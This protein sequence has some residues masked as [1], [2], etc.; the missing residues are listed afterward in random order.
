MCVCLAGR[1]SLPLFNGM[2]SGIE[3]VPIDHRTSWAPCDEDQPPA[4]YDRTPPA[5]P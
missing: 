1:C 5:R 3:H 4:E 2:T